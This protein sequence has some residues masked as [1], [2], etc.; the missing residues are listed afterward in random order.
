MANGAVP[1]EDQI[2]SLRSTF[3]PLCS[4]DCPTRPRPARR[5]WHQ[6][7][8]AAPDEL[9]R[10]LCYGAAFS[11]VLWGIMITAAWALT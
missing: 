11:A 3:L 10:G 1:V 2:M 9:R 8:I 6:P 5:A 4:V 7:A